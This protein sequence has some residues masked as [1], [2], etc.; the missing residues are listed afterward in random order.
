MRPSTQYEAPVVGAGPAGSTARLHVPEG[1]QRSRQ[2]SGHEN[3]RLGA[4]TRRD[5]DGIKAD[6]KRLNGYFPI[7]EGRRDQPAASL[8]GGEQ[9]QLA[10]ARGL[11]SR[12]RLLLLD[13]H[14]VG[15]RLEELSTIALRHDPWI[16]H[17]HAPGVGG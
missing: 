13:E 4:Y 2:M 11:M 16:E 7:L 1:S 14:P 5:R 8:S 10:V 15:E 6:I 12:P 17:D 3:V 9:Q